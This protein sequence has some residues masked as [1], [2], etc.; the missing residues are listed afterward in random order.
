MK[1]FVF[2]NSDLDFDS[3]PIRV[4]PELKKRFPA[5]DF[6]IKDPNEELSPNEK[7]LILDAVEGISDIA[8]FPDLEKF[9]ASPSLSLHDFDAYAALRLLQKLK[10]LPPM[11]I[12]GFPP[13]MSESKAIED[14]SAIFRSILL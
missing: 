6:E 3:L 2:G 14:A 13:F 10:K 11:K 9:V 8:V 1:V 4:L 12:I 5:F 7:F